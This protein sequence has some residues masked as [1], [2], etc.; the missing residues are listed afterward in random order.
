MRLIGKLFQSKGFEQKLLKR[1]L[2]TASEILI[3]FENI[4]T[5]ILN[6]ELS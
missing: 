6:K 5:N 4:N 3:V 1:R 2:L